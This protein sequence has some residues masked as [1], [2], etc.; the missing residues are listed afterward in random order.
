MASV[1]PPS[2]RA[3]GHRPHVSRHAD[4]PETD[5]LDGLPLVSVIVT[6]RNSA[7]VLD[8]C[9]GS[10][11]KQTYP[12]VE[13]IVV[14]NHSS[15][16]TECIA[17]TY[18]DVVATLGPERSAQRNHGALVSRGAFLVFVDADMVLDDDVV[19]QGVAAMQRSGAPAAVIPEVSFGDGFWTRCRVLERGCYV[20]DPLVEA[21]RMYRRDAFTAAGGFDVTLIGPEDW[22]LS[23]RV[24][25]TARPARTEAIIHHD[26][27]RTTLGGAFV[28]RRYYGAGYLLYL[29]KH[30][31]AVLSQG[32]S[33]LRPAFLRQWRTLARHPLLTVGIFSLKSVELAAVMQVAIEWSVFGRSPNRARQVYR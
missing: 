23:R 26:E 20:G 9:L 3:P 17:R 13:L 22:D 2:G 19:T 24:T 32:N 25:Q 12:D 33:V 15:D 6:T 16:G 5:A 14:D 18:A 7:R 21:A 28:K 29:R 1:I 31:R 10:V 8:R 11:R 27:G 4:V 30:G